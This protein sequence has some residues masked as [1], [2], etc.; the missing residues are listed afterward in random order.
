MCAWR[1]SSRRRKREETHLCAACVPCP[2]EAK[3]LGFSCEKNAVV[4]TPA[5]RERGEQGGSRATHLLKVERRPPRPRLRARARLLLHALLVGLGLGDALLLGLARTDLG[6][7]ALGAG[8][9]LAL[10]PRLLRLVRLGRC[11]ARCL[12]AHNEREPRLRQVVHLLSRRARRAGTH[13]LAASAA[14]VQTGDE[15]HL[16]VVLELDI[17]AAEDVHDLLLDPRLGVG[18]AGEDLDALEEALVGESGCARRVE[19][20]SAKILFRVDAQD[21]THSG[22]EGRSSR[23]GP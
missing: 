9:R 3:I 20:L 6:G 8:G 17:P 11:G 7:L 23:R 12:R 18:V 15:L 14:L 4:S 10:V 2:T 13:L 16:G 21:W 22:N 5:Q 19:L 1:A